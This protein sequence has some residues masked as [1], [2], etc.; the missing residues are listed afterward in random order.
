MMKFKISETI[1]D[2][3]THLA[4]NL[5][6]AK[7]AGKKVVGCLCHLYGRHRDPG[8]G[9]GWDSSALHLFQFP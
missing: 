4:L 3:H 7:D 6:M 9:D 8:H 5:E 1:Q 2:V